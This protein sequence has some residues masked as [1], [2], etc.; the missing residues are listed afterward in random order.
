MQKYK[1]E[2]NKYLYLEPKWPLFLKVNPPKTRPKLQSKQGSFRVPGIYIYVYTVTMSCQYITFPCPSTL[3]RKQFLE[4]YMV[5]RKSISTLVLN[6]KYGKTPY[7]QKLGVFSM[8]KTI[9][10][11]GVL[12]PLI[13]FGNISTCLKNHLSNSIP[14]IL[15]A[16]AAT[17]RKQW[18]LEG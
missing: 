18:R 17:A 1:H 8:N 7:I 9:H 6:Q 12:P 11:G 15:K 16:Q 5:N 14:H 2:F 13:I 4:T 10:F 3:N